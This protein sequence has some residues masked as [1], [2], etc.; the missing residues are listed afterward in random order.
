MSAFTDTILITGGTSGLG[1]ETAILLAGQRPTTQIIITGRTAGKDAEINVRAQQ[2]NVVFIP[3][4]LTS[5]A[6]TRAFLPLFRAGGYPPILALLLNAGFQVTD[7]L[8]YSDEDGIEVM[9]A[10]NHVNH[11]LLF[12]LLAPYLADNARVV[13]VASSTHDPKLKRVPPPHYN[14]AEEVAHPPTG[15]KYDTRDEALRRYGLSK[16]C[17]V[18]FAYSLHKHARDAGE[19]WV[20]MA[21]DP[22]VMPTNLYRETKGLTGKLL[23][24][25][26]SSCLGRKMVRDL[27]TTEFVA[28][29]LGRMAVSADFG[30]S[31]KS[32]LYYQVVDVKEIKSSNQSYEIT[33]QEDLWR[34]TVDKVAIGEDKKAKFD[35]LE[36]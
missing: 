30:A 15:P 16:L 26:L 8:R 4:D 35:R 25:A 1:Y 23:N 28:A 27:F 34:W 18:L 7:K 24:Q 5:H 14:T 22:G 2:S 33:L 36:G 9:F 17:N 3:L 21:L 29:T 12:F 11:A 20:I 6:S 13:A 32:G 19:E 31:E 10:V